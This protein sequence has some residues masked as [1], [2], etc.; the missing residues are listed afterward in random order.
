MYIF[1][2]NEEKA[3]QAMNQM[4]ETAS[5]DQKL[6]LRFIRADLLDFASVVDAVKQFQSQESSLHILINN[7]GVSFSLLLRPSS[8]SSSHSR[9]VRSRS[10]S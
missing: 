7:A 2:R 4:K 10:T 9:L 6:D 1:A 5:P 8:E 3:I